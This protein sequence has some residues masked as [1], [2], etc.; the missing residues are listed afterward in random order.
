ML[1]I[2]I[3]HSG[4]IQ[5]NERVNKVTQT[6]SP[7]EILACFVITMQFSSSLLNRLMNFAVKLKPVLQLS[8]YICMGFRCIDLTDMI[9]L[10]VYAQNKCVNR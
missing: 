2:K 8:K 3:S 6:E 10:V 9:F 7:K 4:E 1:Q 5:R